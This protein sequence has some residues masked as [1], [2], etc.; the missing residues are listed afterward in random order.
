MAK[1][2]DNP[3]FLYSTVQ[4]LKNPMAKPQLDEMAKKMGVSSEFIL[5]MLE[6][7]V[8]ALYGYKKIKPV[9]PVIKYGLIV[10]VVSYLLKWFGF[11][12]GLFFMS[13]LK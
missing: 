2:L 3:D 1:F 11:T 10:L 5:R 4:M 9:I 8:S 6:W 7:F 13:F 12:Q